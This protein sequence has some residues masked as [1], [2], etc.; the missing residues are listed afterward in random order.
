MVH[1]ST[2]KPEAF[3]NA[4]QTAIFTQLAQ[5]LENYFN[6]PS[7]ITAD[8]NKNSE[9]SVTIENLTIA[10]DATLTDNNVQQT[11]ESLAEALL[12]GLRRTGVSVNMKK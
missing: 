12:N 10:V 6:K 7:S 3:L 4:S 8:S 5:G 1:G 9:S 2:S 11:G